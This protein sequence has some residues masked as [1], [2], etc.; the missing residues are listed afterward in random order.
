M[1]RE[2]FSLSG[3]GCR[4]ADLS[5]FLL[6]LSRGDVGFEGVENCSRCCSGEG[7]LVVRGWLPVLCGVVVAARLWPFLVIKNYDEM[8]K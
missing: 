3:R 5:R 6:P 7:E 2:T 4:R 8:M 1:F